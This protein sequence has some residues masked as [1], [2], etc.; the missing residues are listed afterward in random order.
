MGRFVFHWS[1]LQGVCVIEPPY[2]GD[3]RGFFMET[4][5]RD[6]FFQAGIDVAFVQDNHSFSRKGTV[7][8][9]H[10]QVEFPQAKLVRV[11]RGEVFDVV[12][13][14]RK[15]SRTFGESL[16]LVLSADNRKQLFVPE[17][18]AHGFLALSDEAELVY[19]CGDFYHPEDEHGVLW[20]DPD[21]EIDWPLERVGEIC[22]SEKDSELPRLKEL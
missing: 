17:G 2:F 3:V 16:G 13:D 9:L 20:S 15:Q 8:G 12:V 5:H 4:Y 6:A 14:V 7:R 18:F 10:F 1:G 22:L 21:L 19:K 11:V